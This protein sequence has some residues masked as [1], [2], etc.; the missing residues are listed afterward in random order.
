M[1]VLDGNG[2]VTLWNDALERILDCPRDRALGH[3]VAAAVPALGKTE[4]PKAI[5][6]VLTIADRPNARAGRSGFRFGTARMLQVRI[7]PGVGGVT[8]L[9]HDVTEQTRAEQALKRSEERLALA[10]E[11]ANDGLWEWDL[12]TPGVL[13]LGPMAARCSACRRLPASAV[14]RNGSNRVHADDVA[15]AQGGARGAP[16]RRDADHFQHEHR[17]RHEDG[18]YRRFL[19]RGVAVRGAGRRS[20]RIAGS[21][22]DTTEQAIA[23]EQLAER[24]VPRSADRAC[25]T[26]RSSSRGSGAG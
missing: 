23:Q 18:T 16:L 26:A 15:G 5:A 7:L 21:L 17:I 2:V 10:A 4:L 9:W 1:S 20:V 12:R 6:E 8:L 14:P 11:G 19:C 22:T 24:R 25:A 13:L 3:T